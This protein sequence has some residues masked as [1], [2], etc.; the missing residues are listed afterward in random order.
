MKEADLYPP[1]KSYLEAQ[2]YTV[3]AEIGACDVMALRGVPQAETLMRMK[4]LA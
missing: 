3:K 1:I 2:G 4:E